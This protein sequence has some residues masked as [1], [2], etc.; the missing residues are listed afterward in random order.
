MTE[1]ITV[2]MMW[3][4]PLTDDPGQPIEG[5]ELVRVSSETDDSLV[6]EASELLHWQWPVEG[7][8]TTTAIGT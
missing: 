2:T 3:M 6:D 4:P 7:P 1:S 8:Q 5:A